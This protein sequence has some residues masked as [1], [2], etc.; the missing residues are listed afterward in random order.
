MRVEEIMTT[1]VVT[2][3]PDETAGTAWSR[4]EREGVRYLLVLEGER[5]LG[6]LSRRNVGAPNRPGFPEDK[7]VRDLFM[8]L[9]ETGEPGM[10]LRQAADIMHRRFVGAL[11]IVADGRLLGVVTAAD[12]FD[13]LSRTSFRWPTRRRIPRPDSL[14][15]VPFAKQIPRERKRRQGRTGA[16]EVPAH[17]YARGAL[18]EYV[19]R[20]YV[21]RKLGRKLG[22]LAPAIERVSVRIE[23]VNGPRGGV[24]KRCHVKVVLTD[25]PS[26][27]IETR[28]RK[29]RRALDSA[30]Q[31]TEHAVRRAVE[32]Q[33][34]AALRSRAEV[35]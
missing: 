17:I 29:L 34:T 25:L 9:L 22:K 16:G 23:D 19:D 6:V 33:R 21:R 13:E 35:S 30:I 5:V 3:S 26:V 10:T 2:I 18:H 8:P 32:K 31:R 28:H 11:P 15:R 20:D 24:D 14:R 7:P 27:V 4:M 1:D 12:V